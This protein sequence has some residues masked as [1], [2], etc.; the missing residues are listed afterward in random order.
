M[1]PLRV[2]L[3]L[4]SQGKSRVAC[5]S[6]SHLGLFSPVGLLKVRRSH[7][8]AALP[9]S[10]SLDSFPHGLVSGIAQF[11]VDSD[12][13]LSEALGQTLLVLFL[14]NVFLLPLED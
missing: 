8:E 2:I 14:L 10:L 4:R 5:G 9:S 6:L 7:S 13:L 11:Q 12:G 1:W 3:S